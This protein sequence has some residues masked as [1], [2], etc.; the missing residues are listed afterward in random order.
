MTTRQGAVPGIE[1]S[2]NGMIAISG[3]KAISYYRLCVLRG[4]VKLEATGMRRTGP[5]ATSIAKRELGVKG[6]RTKVLAALQAAIEE[7]AREQNR[8]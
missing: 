2:D 5:S 3:E 8:P 1:V 6:N 7:M 4:A